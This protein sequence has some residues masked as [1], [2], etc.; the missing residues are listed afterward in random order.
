MNRYAKYKSSGFDWIGEIPSHWM[1]RRVST[2]GEFFK[3]RGIRKDE[4]KSVGLPC[5][6]YGEIYTKYDRIIFNTTSFIDEETSKESELIKKGDV[7]FAGSGET[8]EDIGKAI[9]YFGASDAY[10]GGDTIVLRLQD[11]IDPIY[12]SFL[13]NASFV[14]HQKS[15]SAKGEIIVHIYPKDIREIII[16]LPPKEEQAVIG[17]YLGKKTTQIDSL[18]T[19][20]QKLIELLKEERKVIINEAINGEGKNWKRKKLKYIARIQGGFAF[21]SDDFT[22]IGIQLIKIG[23]LYQNEFSLERQPTFLPTEFSNE[24]KEWLVTDGDILISMTGTLG[25]RDYGYAI[26]I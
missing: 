26:Q 18:I 4:T 23:N 17:N 6:R 9:V 14:Q 15:I 12:A 2:F 8:I 1:V 11:R 5:I 16:P 24:Y 20:K 25:K 10:A 21:N 22:P 19:K 7:L 13:M 3:G